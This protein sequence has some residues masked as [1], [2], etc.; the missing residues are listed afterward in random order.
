MATER[1]IGQIGLGAL[2]LPFARRLHKAFGAL[3]VYDI[4]AKRVAAARRLGAAVARSPRDLAARCDL[5]LLSLP[6]PAAVRAVMEGERG[7]LAGAKPGTVVIDTST[8][9]P[10]TSEAMAKAARARKIGYLDAPVTS[11][12]PG[13]AGVE[14]AKSGTFTVLVGGRK[15]DFHAARPVLDVLGKRV[16]Y[17]GPSGS[18]SVMKLISNH[19]AGISTWAVAEGLALAAACGVPALR[20]MDVLGGTVAASYVMSDDVR[21]RVESGD[22]EPGFSV[23]L[24]HKDLR[25]TGEL[26]RGLNVPLMFNQLAMEMFQLMRAQGRGGKSQMDCV[27]Y[28][29]ELAR[30]DIHAPPSRATRARAVAR[31]RS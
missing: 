23:D 26:G 10:W 17:L 7:V 31:E 1:R 11:G 15:G 14:A 18:G 16:E 3:R 22:F 30:V 25:L 20:A 21:P 24:Y 29:A 28:M 2:G 4:K 9:D 27:N 6:D 12:E 8:V 19:I 5:I 13:F